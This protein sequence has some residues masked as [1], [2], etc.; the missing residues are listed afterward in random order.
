MRLCPRAQAAVAQEEQRVAALDEPIDNPR[1]LNMKIVAA[2]QK[3]KA[4][5]QFMN[6]HIQRC[7][8]CSP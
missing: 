5:A 7:K 6:N 1:T 4:Y 8:R 3:R 2:R